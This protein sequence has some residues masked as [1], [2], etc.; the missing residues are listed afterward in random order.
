MNLVSVPDSE[1]DIPGHSTNCLDRKHN[2]W[3]GGVTLRLPDG[4]QYTDSK[5]G[6]GRKFREYNYAHREPCIKL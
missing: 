3:D 1:V 6:F 4:L 5:E 2:L